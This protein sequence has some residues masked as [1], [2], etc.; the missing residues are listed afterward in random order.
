MSAEQVNWDKFAALAFLVQRLGPTGRLGKKAIQKYFYLMQSLKGINFGHGFRFYTYGPFSAS[1]AADIDLASRFGAISIAYDEVENAYSIT[2][3]EKVDHFL[4]KGEHFLAVNRSKIE[5]IIQNFG[6][7]YA[8]DLE[9]L[10]TLVFVLT[11]RKSRSINVSEFV[12]VTR[13]LK[14]QFSEQRIRDAIDELLK[15]KYFRTNK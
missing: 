2:S 10:A 9:L 5:D 4:R 8:K 3:G 13:K 1:L 7:K 11:N 12:N 6:G 14:P 15:K